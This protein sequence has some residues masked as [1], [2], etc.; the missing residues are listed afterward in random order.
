MASITFR[1]DPATDQA[2][3]LLT[4]D[5]ASQSD[6]IRQALI[7]AARQRR[8]ERLRAEAQRLAAD[9]EYQAEVASVQAD[10]E[11]LRAW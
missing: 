8:R 9:P 6:A 7:T 2:L 4:A 5:G 3:G 11:A 10:M 1:T